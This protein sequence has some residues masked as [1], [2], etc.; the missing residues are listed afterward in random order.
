[1]QYAIHEDFYPEVSKKLTHISKKCAKHG[2]PFTFT[3]TGDEVRSIYDEELGFSVNHRFILVDVEGTARIANWECVAILEAYDAGNVIRKINTAMDIPERFKTSGNLCEHCNSKRQRHNLYIVHNVETEEFKQVGGSCL[4]LYTSGLSLEY[5]AAYMDGI[6]ELE[7]AS[8][9]MPPHR[10][11]WLVE[12]VIGRALELTNLFGYFPSRNEGITTR[13]MVAT[14]VSSAHGLERLNQRLEENGMKKLSSAD[15]WLDETPDTVRKITDYYLSLTDTSDFVT[16]V[17]TLIREGYTSS[18]NFGFLSYLP[19]G[20]HK[21][22]QV[23]E[24]K[25]KREVNMFQGVNE[26]FGTIGKRYKDIKVCCVRRVASWCT[27]YGIQCLYKFLL[28]TGEVLVWS[29]SGSIYDKVVIGEETYEEI[30]TEH[31]GLVGHSRSVVE[32]Q[33]IN[34]YIS[35]DSMTFTVKFHG[36]YKGVK[37]TEISRPKFTYKPI[38]NMTTVEDVIIEDPMDALDLLETE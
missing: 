1:M 33:V 24:E 26:H 21:A 14:L 34:N 13:S 7:E 29:T 19:A 12:D 31:Y 3:V 28:E 38:E 11:L 16:N 8:A 4:K 15:L 30:Q 20:Y 10:N 2:N 5:V 23:A 27:N 9:K 6:T 17:Q 35:V 22:M 32:H 25:K 37:Q 18:K 36:E